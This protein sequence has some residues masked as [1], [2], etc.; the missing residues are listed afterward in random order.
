MSDVPIIPVAAAI[1][2]LMLLLT[3]AVARFRAR[4]HERARRLHQLDS[5]YTSRQ[6]RSY[7]GKR[8]QD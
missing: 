3:I 6:A 7:Y 1:V 8:Q 4:R 5:V 2:V